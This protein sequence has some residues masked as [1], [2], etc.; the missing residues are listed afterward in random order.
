MECVCLRRKVGNNQN[1]S[2]SSTFSLICGF[3]FQILKI[4]RSRIP[5]SFI[6]LKEIFKNLIHCISTSLHVGTWWGM[7][8]TACPLEAGIHLNGAKVNSEHTDYTG[9]VFIPSWNSNKLAF[10]SLASCLSR[11][12]VGVFKDHLFYIFSG[13]SLEII[14]TNQVNPTP[15]KSSWNCQRPG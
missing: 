5:A 8:Q 12:K 2:L 1:W 13:F 3:F 4:L 14:F 7:I 9:S 15:S 10:A 6:L 11:I